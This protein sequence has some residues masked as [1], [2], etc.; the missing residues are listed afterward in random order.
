M[1]EKKS[2]KKIMRNL[3]KNYWAISTIVLAVILIAVIAFG[4]SCGGNLS[5]NVVGE[6]VVE[7]AKAQGVDATLL[8]VEEQGG[9]YEVVLDIDGQTVPVY[10]TKDGTNLVPSIV[11]LET[12]ETNT[13]TQTTS[14]IPT[15]DKPTVELFVMSYCPYGTQIEKGI[16]PVVELLGDKIDFQLKFVYYAMHPTAGEVEENTRQYCIQKEQSDKLTDYLSCFLQAGDSESCLTQ[17]GI[18]QAKLD[19]CYAEADK[20]FDIT[21][22]LEDTGSWLSGSYPQYN[23]NLEDNE[24]YSVGGSPTLVINGATIVSNEQYCGSATNCVVDPSIGRS[25]ASLLLGICKSF[26][27]APEECNTELSGETPSPGFGYSTTTS[28]TTATCG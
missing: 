15:S 1:A 24:K 12:E 9:L 20:E 5:G 22:N 6:R 23:V 18:D 19:A 17:T 2:L 26:N 14:T 21:T 13:N 11:P 25:P 8:S 27:D 28:G 7:F 10:A 3:S 16:L 4:N